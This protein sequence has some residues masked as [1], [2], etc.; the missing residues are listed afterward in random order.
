MKRILPIIVLISSLV[1]IMAA[2]ASAS[3]STYTTD[4]DFGPPAVS[5]NVVIVD[6]GEPAYLQLDNIV[7]PFD[8]IWVAVSSRG[9]VVKI[10]TNTGA[11]LGEYLTSPDGNGN[12]S[13]TTVD[14]NGNVWVANRN[15]NPGTV[16]HIASVPTDQDNDGVIKT[17]TGLGDILLWGT[18]EAVLHYV[19]VN[20]WGTRHLSVD[21]DNNVWVSGTGGTRDF[22]LI[23][24]ETGLIIASH[25]G[26]IGYGGYGGLIDPN[27]VIWSARDLLRWDTD[28]PL[29]A[30]NSYTTTYSYYDT[31]G[32]GIDS[33][34]NVWNTVLSGNQIRKFAPDGT[35]I[36]TYNHGDNN[37]QG[38]VADC[39]DHI[40]VA[41]TLYAGKNT[42]GHL[43]N[44][45][46]FIGNVTLAPAGDP[47]AGPTGVAVDANGK[48]WATGYINGKVYRIDPTAGALGADGTTP[49]GAVDLIVDIGGKLYNYSDMTGSTLIAPPNN[50]TWSVD[51][52]SGIIDPAWDTI[53]WTA[54][55]PGDSS[56]Y[57][58]VA[59]STNGS[60]FGSSQ[61]VTNGGSLGFADGHQYLRI[62][63]AFTR[64]STDSDGDDIKDS[65]ILYD[66]TITRNQPPDCTAAY[67]DPGCLW[68]PNH[69]FVDVSIMGV[70]DPDGDPVTISIY[71]ITSDEPTE[72]DKGSGGATHAPDASGIGTDTASVRA[73]RSGKADGR[74]YV[75][76]F[77]AI[78]GRGGEC[79]GTVTV[80]VPHDQSSEDCPAIDSGQNYYATE[81]N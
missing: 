48:I 31:Y 66:L 70:T 34:G 72:S 39:D 25:T 22:D 58:S 1:L 52:D 68:P 37:A 5:N 26:V 75:I 62:E 44:D 47:A 45:G 50:G 77:T 53:S 9:T 3:S 79:E 8:F 32:L 41:H 14:N 27:G 51:H 12:P 63:V 74:V 64:S 76:H 19:T 6:T 42:V 80:N 46:T 36:N 10:D 67:A 61:S 59:S 78:D 2:P 49:I 81:L 13:R 38:C 23:D 43:L 18:D 15:P 4:T 65:P 30:G 35:L 54:D 33:S 60:D 16:I 17:S 24:G 56:I 28:G 21:K 73:E 57:V 20:S 69:K 7:T 29:I 11:V 40:W 55:E 71:A